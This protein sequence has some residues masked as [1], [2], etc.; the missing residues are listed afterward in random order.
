MEN[1]VRYTGENFS[2][3]WLEYLKGQSDIIEMW[4]EIK[5]GVGTICVRHGK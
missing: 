3:S 1:L 5:N 2:K 4:I